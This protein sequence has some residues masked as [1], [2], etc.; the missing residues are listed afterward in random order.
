MKTIIQFLYIYGEEISLIS[1]IITILSSIGMVI[2]YLKAKTARERTIIAECRQEI[3]LC[4]PRK[5][6]RQ[7]VLAQHKKQYRSQECQLEIDTESIKHLMGN[8]NEVNITLEDSNDA[9]KENSSNS[10]AFDNDVSN[11]NISN[12]KIISKNNSGNTIAVICF[13]GFLSL[14]VICA[15][16]CAVVYFVT[17]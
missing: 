9:F 7:K 14:T 2:S 17:H 15:T 3:T 1:G 13:F 16:V 8:I 12:S 6:K 4:K 10:V 5:T 11:N